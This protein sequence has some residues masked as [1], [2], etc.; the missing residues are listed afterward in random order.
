LAVP[1]WAWVWRRR[2][3]VLA[4][5]TVILV[6]LVVQIVLG[7]FVV[8]LEL[9]P[10]VVAVHLGVAFLI[11]GTLVWLAT[12][13]APPRAAPPR[14]APPGGGRVRG[15]DPPRRRR[16]PGDAGDP[17]GPG[18]PALPPPGGRDAGRALRARPRRGLH[19]GHGGELGLH[20]LPRLHRPADGRPGGGG[21]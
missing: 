4:P 7:A 8:R 6:L 15:R 13:A 12:A 20:R 14:A 18:G 1:V 3:R 16:G 10:S 17:G 5:A 19:P 9:P 11:L 21:H 2:R